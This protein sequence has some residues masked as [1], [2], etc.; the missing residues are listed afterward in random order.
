MST[1]S[2]LEINLSA[3]DILRGEGADPER[4]K[5]RKPALVAAAER[6]IEEG[7]RLI[8]PTAMVETYPVAKHGHGMILL[9]GPGKLTGP[10][11]VRHLAGARSITAAV[12][13]IGEELEKYSCQIFNEDP[14]LAMAYDGLGNAAM[15]ALGQQVCRRI[16]ETAQLEMLTVSTPLSPGEPDWP[17]EIGQ[18]EV[19]ALNAA[20]RQFV[21]ITP[22]GMMIPKKTISFVVGIGSD[23]AQDEPCEVCNLKGTCRYRKV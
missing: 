6:S 7:F 3:D 5:S 13:T 9:D 16:A 17:V 18:P 4:I 23:M 12:C 22:G 8:H 14:L 1:W 19:F 2:D 21:R 11:V 15:E 10:L 20:A